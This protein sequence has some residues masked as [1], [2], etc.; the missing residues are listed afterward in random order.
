METLQFLA[1]IVV[2]YLLGSISFSI[3]MSRSMG[4]DVRK[5]GSGN[6][7]ATNMARIFGFKAGILTLLGDM[8]KAVLAM[9]LGAVLM[10]DLGIAAAGL[11]VLVGHCFPVFHHFHGGKGVSV[12]AAIAAAVDWRVLVAVVC[13]F[14][15]G[16]LLTKKVSV[17]SVCAA[18]GITVAALAFGITGPKLVLCVCGMCLVVYQ[19]RENLRR[20]VRGEE[21]DFKMAKNLPS[22]RKGKKKDIQA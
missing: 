20:L 15:A 8:F 10:G 4:C 12:G 1:I 21:P 7:G 18:V 16:A 2:G 19:H 22:I 11:A 9:V 6:A 13:A 3:G 17:G 14:F 5:K